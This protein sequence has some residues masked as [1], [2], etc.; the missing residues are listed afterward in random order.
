MP[1][2]K[3]DFIRTGCGGTPCE[4]GA[5]FSHQLVWQKESPLD[6]GIFVPVNMTGYTAKMQVRKKSSDPVIIE[7]STSNSRIV[8]TPLLGQID[9]LIPATNTNTMPA[10]IFA[11]DLELTDTNDFVTRFIEGKFEVVG[12]ITV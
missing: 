6:S 12:Q 2:E 10:G 9:L 7:L 8:I 3:Y 5:T 11:Y 1:A 4:Q